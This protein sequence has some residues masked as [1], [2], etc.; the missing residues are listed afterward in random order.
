[1]GDRFPK[2]AAALT[3]KPAAARKKDIAGAN[4]AQIANCLRLYSLKNI[5]ARAH[6]F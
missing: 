5:G 2:K 4:K 3:A 6:I 1:M